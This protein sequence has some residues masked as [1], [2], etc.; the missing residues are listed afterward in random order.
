MS[1][2]AT[3]S[4]AARKPSASLL[5]VSVIQGGMGA[6]ISS[7][8]LANTVSRRGQLGVV[9]GVALDLLLARRLQDGDTDGAMRRALAAFPDA[10]LVGRI[11]QRYF[12]AAGREEGRGYLAKPLVGDRPSVKDEELLI[13][14]GF[15]EVYLAKEGHR[16]LVGINFLHKIQPPL[17][18]TL[19]GA[20]LAG[21]DVVIVGAGIPVQLPA[22]L[23]GLARD[24]AVEFT[25]EVKAGD[26]TD[27]KPAEHNLRFDPRRHLGAHRPSLVRPLF[28]PI[29]SSATLA[30]MLVRKC[31]KGVNGLV[32]EYSTAGGHNAPPRGRG[33]LSDAGEPIYGPRDVVDLEVVRKLGVPFWLAGSFGDAGGVS[34]A[35]S[36]GARGVQVG[37]L[38]AFCAESGLRDDLKNQVVDQCRVAAPRPFTDPKASPTGFPFKLLPIEGT[39]SD[40]ELYAQRERRC[41]L[42]YL[43]EAYEQA[44]GS[45]GW[46]CAAEDPA[47]YV[48]KGGK[49]EDTVGRKC[50]CNALA[51]NVDLAQVRKG[52]VTELPMLTTGDDLDCIRA[53]LPAGASGYSADQV[54]DFL[55]R[56]VVV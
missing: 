21:V 20:M 24:E 2:S 14:S 54:L 8:Q 40:P 4:A 53:V 31:G 55:L 49:L 26:G 29:V 12:R 56:R 13:A 23:D 32:V 11:L 48:R 17:L 36:M 28:L 5:Q 22:I 18:A 51:A 35:Q 52:G 6:G 50:L 25:L 9:S 1:T 44:D 27:A 7:S 43:R 30:T 3:I 16:G 39:L 46:R 33:E 41:D 42:G 45:V 47:S 37:T 34:R 10:G 38:F 19:W 15:V